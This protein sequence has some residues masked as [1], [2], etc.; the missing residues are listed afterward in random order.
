VF[1]MTATVV[2]VEQVVVGADGEIYRCEGAKRRLAYQRA[3][4]NPVF[5]R[6]SIAPLPT[7]PHPIKDTTK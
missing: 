1:V 2:K 6:L 3:V 7:P 5:S 4:G